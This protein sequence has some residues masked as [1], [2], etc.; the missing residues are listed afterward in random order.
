MQ[1]ESISIKGKKVLSYSVRSESQV[2]F[3]LPE[4]LGPGVYRLELTLMD[5]TELTWPVPFE[6]T[7]P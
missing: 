1:I 2:V 7:A 5:G 3:D 4:D 6:V